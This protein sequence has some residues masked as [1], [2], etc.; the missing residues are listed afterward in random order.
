MSEITHQATIKDIK[1][2]I[3]VLEIIKTDA[4]KSCSLKNICEQKKEILAKINHSEDYCIGDNVIVYIS[5]KQAIA[6]IFLGYILPLLF[7]VAT[8]FFCLRFF[9]DETTSALASLSVL[10]IYYTF[11]HFFDKKIKKS[12]SVKIEQP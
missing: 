3:A 12:L 8:L 5:E 4:C 6:A 7:V 11:L 9:G 2:N 10:P 1:E